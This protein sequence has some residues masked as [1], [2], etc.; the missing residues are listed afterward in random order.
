MEGNNI[1]CRHLTYDMWYGKL[2]N[3]AEIFLCLNY[4]NGIT[5]GRYGNNAYM[6]KI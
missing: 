5:Q 2:A 6:S 4:V 3:V 1:F